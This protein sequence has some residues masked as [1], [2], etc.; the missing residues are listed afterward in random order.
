MQLVIPEG[1]FDAYIFDCDGTLADTMPLHYQAWCAALGV[2]GCEFPEDLFYSFGGIPTVKIV[3]L[4]NERNGLAMPPE[5][6][7]HHKEELFLERLGRI[8]PI[9]AAVAHVHQNYGRIP[10]AVASGGHREIVIRTLGTLGLLE[11]FEVIVGAEDYRCGKPAPDPFLEA[12]RRL[13]CDPTRCLVFEDTEIGLQAAA[14]AG[15]KSVLVPSR[16]C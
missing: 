6:T 4:L 7:A 9:E 14:A 3:Q 8:R 16:V 2:H 5:A 13:G 10:L 1:D 15:M 12:A 11:K